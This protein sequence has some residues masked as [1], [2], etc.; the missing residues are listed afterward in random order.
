MAKMY[1]IGSRESEGVSKKTGKAFHAFTL[2]CLRRDPQSFGFGVA[3]VYIDV[4]SP[5]FAQLSEEFRSITGEPAVYDKG[6]F[7]GAYLDVDF[8]RSGF[9]ESCEV[10]GFDGDAVVFE[11]DWKKCGNK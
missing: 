4:N 3:E 6:A 2:S 10:I 7:L 1:V 8:N 9:V 11:I 5:M